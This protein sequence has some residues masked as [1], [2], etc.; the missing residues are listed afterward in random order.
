MQP[1]NPESYYTKM[2]QLHDGS[3]LLSLRPSCTSSP[4]SYPKTNPVPSSDTK[5]RHRILTI[6]CSPVNLTLSCLVPVPVSVLVRPACLTVDLLHLL[7]LN[8]GA[9]VLILLY[10][11]RA[12][13]A[14]CVC[15]SLFPAVK[16]VLDNYRYKFDA[17]TVLLSSFFSF[18]LM[19]FWYPY[20]S[21]SQC[22]F[23]PSTYAVEDFI[24]EL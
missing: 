24:V 8:L 1:S 22:Q 6:D 12:C 3:I 15:F 19:F 13:K 10:T 23:N 9:R 14:V 21:V 18:E 7:D 20:Q 2:L 17:T 5:C 16:V 4:A 11:A